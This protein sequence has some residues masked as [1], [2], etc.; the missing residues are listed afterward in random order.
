MIVLYLEDVVR[1]A[2]YSRC[3]YRVDHLLI[4]RAYENPIAWDTSWSI[5]FCF[6]FLPIKSPILLYLASSKSA[7]CCWW[8]QVLQAVAVKL[9]LRLS[10][11]ISVDNIERSPRHK[12]IENR[13]LL[14]GIVVEVEKLCTEYHQQRRC[15]LSSRFLQVW[16]H[17][18]AQFSSL[19]SRRRQG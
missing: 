19:I 10:R 16:R 14:R 4:M 9:W 3:R 15:R 11:W 1:G 18:S 5:L 12:R 8:D 17:I 7:R 13:D 6:C 2:R